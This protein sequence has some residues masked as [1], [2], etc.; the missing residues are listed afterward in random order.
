MQT[1]FFFTEFRKSLNIKF[2]QHP[3][4][5]SRVALSAQTDGHEPNSPFSQFCERAQNLEF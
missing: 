3:S 5:G 1:D 2:Y 4:S